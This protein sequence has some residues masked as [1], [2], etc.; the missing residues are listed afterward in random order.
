[1]TEYIESIILSFHTLFF[2]TITAQAALVTD[3]ART[4]VV[5]SYGDLGTTANQFVSDH[6][7]FAPL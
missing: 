5:F 3:F 6:V 1:M 4:Y 2:Q 7:H